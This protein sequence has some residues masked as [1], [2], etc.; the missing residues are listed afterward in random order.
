VRKE[1]VF[2]GSS[3]EAEAVARK[4]MLD[5]SSSGLD[6]ELEFW[7]DTVWENLKDALT[8]IESSINSYDYA[9][10]VGHPDD[11]ATV[12]GTECYLTRDNVIFE[13]GLFF[14]R[15]GHKR[16]FFVRPRNEE[17]HIFSDIGKS[18]TTGIYEY[19]RDE[20]GAVTVPTSFSD[21]IS[22]IA[23]SISALRNDNSPRPQIDEETQLDKQVKSL[24]TEIQDCQRSEA[25]TFN[26]SSTLKA[27]IVPIIHHKSH[28]SNRDPYDVAY[29]FGRS[30][31]MLDDLVDLSQLARLQRFDPSAKRQL[32]SVKV[33]AEQPI[34]LVGRGSREIQKHIDELRETVAFNLR[35]D[36]KYLY[37]T[38]NNFPQKMLENIL[39]LHS[40][41]KEIS[42]K[43]IEI[44]KLPRS[45]FKTIFTIH[46]FADKDDVYMSIIT[47]NRDD[48]L[49]KL[50]HQH[51]VDVC[52]ILDYLKGKESGEDTRFM[53]R[54]FVAD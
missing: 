47:E 10:F 37:F 4:L 52:N 49:I 8:S 23:R 35:N 41:E 1:R 6:L 39:D 46:S 50:K 43:N 44:I 38:S 5:L 54:D 34:E 12:Q 19:V 2:I 17:F 20:L 29:D 9:I 13:F 51:G 21:A 16:T 53:I 26:V 15:L 42:K 27:H 25:T 22:H 40:I 18:V 30:F 33:V 31:S 24:L 7:K 14:S 28:S 45:Y 11:R 32:K 3:N 48:L 36:I